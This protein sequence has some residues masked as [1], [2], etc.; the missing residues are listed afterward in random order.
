MTRWSSIWWEVTK[1]RAKVTDYI[2]FL[3]LKLLSLRLLLLLRL[4]LH[5]PST[6]CTSS[7]AICSLLV[8]AVA[9]SINKNCLSRFFNIMLA[10]S[11]ELV[12]G[13]SFIRDTFAGEAL[14]GQDI[15]CNGW[16]APSITST[17][18]CY[19]SSFMNLPTCRTLSIPKGNT[20]YLVS[21]RR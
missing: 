8:P 2:V 4:F 3:L 16:I 10:L 20:G 12:C 11:H 9:L 6:T 7:T 15:R 13:E 1:Y 18:T 19:H 21:R 14:N 17:S 5:F